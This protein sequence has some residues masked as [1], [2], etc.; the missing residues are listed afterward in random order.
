MTPSAYHHG[1]ATRK[2]KAL[3]VFRS[4]GSDIVLDNSGLMGIMTGGT[5]DAPVVKGQL[6]TDPLHRFGNDLKN[7][8]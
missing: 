6:D 7:L 1:V 4:L 5:R 2:S 3:V 8:F